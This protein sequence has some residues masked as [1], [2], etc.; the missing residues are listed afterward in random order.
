MRPPD[1]KTYHHLAGVWLQQEQ[2]QEQL[3]EA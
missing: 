2:L 3:H 1:A